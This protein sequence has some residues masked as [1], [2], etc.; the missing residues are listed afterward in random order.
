M[1]LKNYFR[2]LSYKFLRFYEAFKENPFIK[3]H[4]DNIGILEFFS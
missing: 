1:S 4:T 3:V 2:R